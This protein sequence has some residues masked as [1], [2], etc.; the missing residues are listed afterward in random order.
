VPASIPVHPFIGHSHTDRFQTT[1]RFVGQTET[2][3]FDSGALEYVVTIHVI[4]ATYGP[5]AAHV[6]L[7]IDFVWI[8]DNDCSIV[9]AGTHTLDTQ[10]AGG[11]RTYNAYTGYEGV[12]TAADDWVGYGTAEYDCSGTLARQ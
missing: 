6:E 4:A 8:G 2:F 12:F 3:T 7:E 10:V 1:A 11:S 5:Q 9:A